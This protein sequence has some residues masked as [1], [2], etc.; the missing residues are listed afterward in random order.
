LFLIS[1][2]TSLVSSA[3]SYA[4]LRHNQSSKRRIAAQQRFLKAQQ[5]RII[6]SDVAFN[7]F[8]TLCQAKTIPEQQNRKQGT[9]RC[10]T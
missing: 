5:R 6:L 1:L 2:T 4:T 10:N 9:K 3:T 7:V 8:L